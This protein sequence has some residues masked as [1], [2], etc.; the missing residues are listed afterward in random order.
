[1]D[2][3]KLTSTLVLTFLITA[4]AAMAMD[5]EQNQ[6]GTPKKLASP[7]EPTT[8][9]TPSRGLLYY[10]SFG[11]A[12]RGD[13]Q[14]LPN[15]S[16]ASSLSIEEAAPKTFRTTGDNISASNKHSAIRIELSNQEL[17]NDAY[18]LIITHRTREEG[19]SVRIHNPKAQD[20]TPLGLL[21]VSVEFSDISFDLSDWA[22]TVRHDSPLDSVLTTY[23]SFTN[24]KSDIYSFKIHSGDK[25]LK[26]VILGNEASETQPG[27]QVYGP[28]SHGNV[29]EWSAAKQDDASQ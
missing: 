26:E 22:K 29:N 25:T 2:I 14:Q 10:L 8:P 27:I 18:Q 6:L 9:K 21:P 19:T 12:G 24:G 28:E 20:Y 7:I 15:T 4:P 16:P 11:Y 13:E 1:M 5:D 3:K 17:M 23:L